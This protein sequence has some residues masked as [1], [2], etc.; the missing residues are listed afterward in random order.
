[1]SSESDMNDRTV[2]GTLAFLDWLTGKHYA[3]P[4]QADPWR[5]AIRKIFTA[6][7]GGEADIESIDWSALD[8]DEYLTR[9]QK[10]AGAD[11]KAESIVTYGRRLRNALDAHQH[12][13]DTGRAPTF[14][15]GAK[16]QKSAEPTKATADVVPLESKQHAGQN[17]PAPQGSM[18]TFP[19]PLSN[20]QMASLT[21]PRR[22][23]SDDVNR[24][25]TFIRTLQDDSPE[26]K[27]LPPGDEQAA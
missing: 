22:M 4:A 21:L 8:L 5:T 27:Q 15:A 1:M 9:F 6:V 10:A 18:V 14:R 19:Y 17:S 7:E 23:A 20:G 16:R 12:Y 24:I 11:Y 13:L 2:G 26:R 3:T 25:T